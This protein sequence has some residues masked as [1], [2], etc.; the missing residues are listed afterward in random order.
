MEGQRPLTRIADEDEQPLLL[1]FG[2]SRQAAP[3][4]GMLRRSPLRVDCTAVLA[5]G[6]RL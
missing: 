6:S 4:R 5:P 2:A 3:A 1:A